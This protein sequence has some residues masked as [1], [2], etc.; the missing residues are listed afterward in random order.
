[1]FCFTRW[2][3]EGFESSLCYCARLVW[4]SRAVEVSR[5]QAHIK[6]HAKDQPQQVLSSLFIFSLKDIEGYKF[7][8]VRYICVI[9]GCILSG[10]LLRLL[11]HWFP[12]WMLWCTHK[13]C[14]LNEA[15]K[16]KIKVWVLLF[17]KCSLN[18]NRIFLVSTSIKFNILHE[19]SQ[20]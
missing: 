9:I 20:G 13:V 2:K 10:G 3:S 17:S 7:S 15:N 19:E 16:V 11:F 6:Y 5:S 4:C 8:Y 14:D 18:F 1:M 12:H